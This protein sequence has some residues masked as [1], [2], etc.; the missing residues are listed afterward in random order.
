MYITK[1]MVLT[2]NQWLGLILELLLVLALFFDLM[3]TDK[4]SYIGMKR[5]ILNACAPNVC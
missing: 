4:G 3:L 5:N 2:L 1:F